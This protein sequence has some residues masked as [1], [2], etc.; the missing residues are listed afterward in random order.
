MEIEERLSAKVLRVSVAYSA[1]RNIASGQVLQKKPYEHIGA[2][3]T[4]VSTLRQGCPTIVDYW[5]KRLGLKANKGPNC[6]LTNGRR[7]GCGSG[8]NV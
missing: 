6:N 7:Q 5:H 2:N 3:S 4:G 8:V 1:M